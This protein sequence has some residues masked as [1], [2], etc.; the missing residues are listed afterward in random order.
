MLVRRP[1]HEVF[2]ALVDPST[3]TRFWLSRSSGP[4]DLGQTVVR[5]FMDSTVLDVE[6]TGFRGSGSDK[7]DATLDA[8]QGFTNVL[9]DL[10]T[11][12]ESGKQMHLT[13][14][15]ALLTVQK[16]ADEEGARK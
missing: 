4:L 8:T 7:V 14:D 6:N 13:R 3:I 10:K 12:L 1:I 9:C 16:L 11:F 15:K 2:S 5:D